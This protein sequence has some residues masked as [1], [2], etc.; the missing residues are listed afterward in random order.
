MATLP[1]SDIV[2]ITVS[3]SAS[4]TA[5]K[6]FNIGLIVGDSTFISAAIRTKEYA[7]ADSMI[8]DGFT[9]SDKEY[10]AAVLYFSQSPRP[11]RVVIGRWDKT[12]SET[13]LAAV[14]ACRAK[15]TDWYTFTVCGAGKTDI[16]ALAGYA[17]T[18]AP[19]AAYFYTTADADVKTGV[20]GNIFTVLKG[21]K[22]TRSLGIYSMTAD[23]AAAAMGYAMGANTRLANSAYTLAYKTLSGVTVDNLSADEVNMIKGNNGNV[24]VSRGNTYTLF[25]NGVVSS[26]KFFDEII[27]TDMLVNDIQTGIMDLLSSVAKVTQTED[28]VSQIV[29]S[30]TNA[31]DGAVDRGFL[32]PGVWSAASFKSVITGDML[33]KGYLILA[34]SIDTQNAADRANRLAPNIYVL[35][36]LA[37]AIHVVKIQVNVN[38]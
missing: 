33:S 30:I 16:Q 14:Q 10:K 21:L 15:N 11:N 35:C 22:Y 9:A 38:A 32:A 5:L 20:A 27:N 1:L 23:A 24:Y 7:D 8:A 3:A 37:G 13:A 31:C 17:E 2:N 6:G 34:D 12:G 25:E 36:K 19:K 29:S 28:G 18:A 26:G 4:S